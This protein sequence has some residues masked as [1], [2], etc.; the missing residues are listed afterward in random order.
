MD[1]EFLKTLIQPETLILIPVLYLIGIMIRKT[2]NIPNWVDAWV[3]LV[4][5]I[6]ACLFIVGSN[7]DAFIQG[8][9]VAGAASLMTDL[10]DRTAQGVQTEP[11]T[12]NNW[13]KPQ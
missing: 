6:V 11:I 2:P 5:G 9:L 12:K 3:Q 7:V 1:F 10:I 8:V 4:V 13:N